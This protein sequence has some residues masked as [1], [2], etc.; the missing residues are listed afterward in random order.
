M[1]DDF[2]RQGSQ[3]GIVLEQVRQC[4]RVGKIVH[5]RKLNV[6]PVEAR[7]DDVPADAAK[8]INANFHCHIF[9]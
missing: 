4:F 2:L 3:H 6:V 1:R 5:R 9:S 8:A 7:S